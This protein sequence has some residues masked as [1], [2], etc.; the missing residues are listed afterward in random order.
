MNILKKLFKPT[1]VTPLGRWGVPANKRLT[2]NNVYDH[3]LCTKQP[4]KFCEFSI[5]NHIVYCKK[6]FT[7]VPKT[8][9]EIT[10]D[11][12]D[13]GYINKSKCKQR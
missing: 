2:A 11:S 13:I 12:H 3:S 1:N 10:L 5:L 6:C 9:I 4:E 8:N 7:I